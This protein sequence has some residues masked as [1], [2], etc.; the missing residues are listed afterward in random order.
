MLT[1]EGDGSTLLLKSV[2]CPYPQSSASGFDCGLR[3]HSQRRLWRTVLLCTCFDLS[4]QADLNYVGLQLLSTFCRNEPPPSI[5]I[6]YNRIPVSSIPIGDISESRQ[7]IPREATAAEKAEFAA[8]LNQRW[9]AK[10]ALLHDFVRQRSHRILE[11][12]R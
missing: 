11:V 5:H 1:T 4:P 7:G 3:R 6:H 8:W 2:S 9:Q 12:Y 10:D